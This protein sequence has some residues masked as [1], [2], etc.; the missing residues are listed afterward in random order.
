MRKSKIKRKTKETDIEILLNID[1]K[2]V[3]GIDTGIN[4]FNHMLELLSKHGLFD[5]YAK[6]KGDLDVDQHHTVEDVG[7]ALG[8]AFDKALGDKKGINRAGYFVFPMDESL[9]IVALDIGGRPYLKFDVKFRKEKIGDL[10]S[11]LVHDFFEGFTAHLKANLHVRSIEGRTDHH[12]VEAI[13]KAVGKA[14]KIACSRDKRALKELP[15]TKG[16]I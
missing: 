12:K 13:F 9:A 3:S 10:D 4:F 5:L 15:S 11:E 2:G 6:A 8:D 14:L 1:G 16:L 7:I